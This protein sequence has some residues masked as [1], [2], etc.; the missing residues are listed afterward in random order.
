MH[1]SVV[2]LTD[3]FIGACKMMYMILFDERWNI[4]K[5][6]VKCVKID[7]KCANSVFFDNSYYILYFF[8]KIFFY[9]K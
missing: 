6:Q 2:Q 5:Q 7:K 8:T 3:P 9:L 4:F 1:I